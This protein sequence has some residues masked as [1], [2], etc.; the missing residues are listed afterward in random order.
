[1]GTI[2]DRFHEE[3]Y[4]D[5][6]IP[7]GPKAKFLIVI[8]RTREIVLA[9]VYDYHLYIQKIVQNTVIWTP[10]NEQYI[11]IKDLDGII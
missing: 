3:N 11:I 5:R 1:M 4:I 8:E 9:M 10:V 7:A 2:T 6:I